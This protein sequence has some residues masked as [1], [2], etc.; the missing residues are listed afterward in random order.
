MAR[1]W[2]SSKALERACPTPYSKKSLNSPGEDNFDPTIFADVARKLGL[3]KDLKAY[4]GQHSFTKSKGPYR[5][6]RHLFVAGRG[7]QMPRL[8]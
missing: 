8:P 5:P 2:K 3:D 4:Q 6:A 1:N 7:P